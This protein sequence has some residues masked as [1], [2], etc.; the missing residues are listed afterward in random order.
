MKGASRFQRWWGTLALI[1]LIATQ[2][3]AAGQTETVTYYYTDPNGTVLATS[4]AAGN[5]A[6]AIDYRPYGTQALGTPSPG[7]GY[8]GH[9]NDPDSGLVYMQARYYDPSIGRF[10]STDPARTG[11]G[12]LDQFNRFAYAKNN[13]VSNIDPDGRQTVPRDAYS[14]Y[15][16][17]APANDLFTQQNGNAA[18]VVSMITQSDVL[19][20]APAGSGSGAVASSGF[21]GEFLAAGALTRGAGMLASATRSALAGGSEVAALPRMRLTDVTAKG[22][23]MQNYAMNWTKGQFEGHLQANGYTSRAAGPV[24]LWSDRSGVK[25]FTTRDFSK[26]GGPTGE[27][28]HSGQDSPVAKFRFDQNPGP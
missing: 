11:E 23:R 14:Q 6:R 26:S 28:F 1:F 8:T 2:A 15:W 12:S 4:D 17:S 24:T 18:F 27:L 3:N 13:P 20:V 5:V 7:P 25:V 10:L 9:V 21:P 16:S 22:A 19:D